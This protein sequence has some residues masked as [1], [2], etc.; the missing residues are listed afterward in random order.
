MKI[1]KQY[2][3][4][5]IKEEI[6]KELNNENVL[7]KIK[8]VFSGNKQPQKPKYPEL[9]NNLKE[10]SNSNAWGSKKEA[11]VFTAI[12]NLQPDIARELNNI[13][14]VDENQIYDKLAR[15]L[16]HLLNDNA[17]TAKPFFDKVNAAI[18]DRKNPFDRALEIQVLGKAT[19]YGSP[20]S[21]PGLDQDLSYLL[22]LPIKDQR[23]WLHRNTD[24]EG[25]YWLSASDSAVRTAIENEINKPSRR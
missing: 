1:S 14:F 15:G 16:F 23:S 9:Q 22:D 3:K 20:F 6:E 18:K 25:G 21:G 12:N 10:I 5:I 8:G 7:S 13:L 19:E 2:L 17:Y 4:Q 24:H 11:E